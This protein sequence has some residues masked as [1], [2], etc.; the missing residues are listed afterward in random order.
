MDGEDGRSGPGAM[1]RALY[2][3][4]ATYSGALSFS[5]GESFL[6][7]QPGKSD[8]WGA[9][10]SRP[11]AGGEDIREVVLAVCTFGGGI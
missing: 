11:V 5:E 2:S 1:L 10:G 6:E 3:F 4:K 7:L 8:R 9:A